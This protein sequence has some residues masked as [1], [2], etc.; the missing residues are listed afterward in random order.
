MDKTI[1]EIP[2]ELLEAAK[3]TAEEAKTHLAIRLYQL[4][5]L[6]DEQAA[7]LAGDPK[8]M[9]T[10]VWKNQATGRFDMDD[11]LSWA[12]HD[13]KTPLNAIIGFTKVVLKGID[14]PIN[15]TQTVDLTTAFNG[16]QRMLT[17]TNYL[18]EMARLNN[19]QIT[20]TP[21]ECNIADLI[22]DAADRW[23]THNLTTPL[24]VNISITEPAFNVDSNY[25]RVVITNLLTY[26]AMRV[27]EG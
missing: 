21:K 16:G 3:I 15:E 1:I 13:L 7:A 5:K 14:G 2:T 6:N 17:L 11:F 18:V 12:S 23:K 25:L 20:L 22:T 8:A 4:H 9:E 26:A 10:L 27:T 24:T 19:G